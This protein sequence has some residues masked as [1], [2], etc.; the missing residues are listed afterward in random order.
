IEEQGSRGAGGAGGDGGEG[1]VGSVGRLGDSETR[2]RGEIPIPNRFD[3]NLLSKPQ[4]KVQG[5]G[6]IEG[7]LKPWIAAQ[8]S[9]QVFLGAA[10]GN[11]Q[12][13]AQ[14]LKEALAQLSQEQGTQLVRIYPDANAVTN[15]PV[16]QRDGKTI[17]LIQSWG[18][19]VEVGDWGQFSEKSQPDYDELL[20]AGRGDEIQFI[21]AAEYLELRKEATI[22][23]TKQISK[24]EWEL[25]FGLKDWLKKLGQQLK[26]ARDK[27]RKRLN[28]WGFSQGT[29][30][31]EAKPDASG[32]PNYYPA[33]QRL[34]T[35]ETT[36]K[37]T[38]DSSSTGTGKSFDTGTILPDRFDCKRAF[39]ITTDP[40]NPSTPTLKNWGYLDG[41]HSGLIEDE[42]GKL[43]RVK[44]GEP[45]S[46]SP[47]CF[48]TE[49]IAA[50]RDA[51]IRG[52]DDSDLVCQ[53]CPWFEA[54]KGGYV[55]GYLA[56]RRET[57]AEEYRI[58]S[59]P[60]SLPNE[61]EFQDYADSLL[62]WEEWE[63]VLTATREIKVHR[64]DLEKLIAHLLTSA[65]L[66]FTQLQPLLI[67]ISKI[68]QAKQPTRY[69]WNHQALVKELPRLP[70]DLALEAIAMTTQPNLTEVLDPFLEYGT[71]MMDLSSGVRKK[72]AES[73]ETTSAKARD[74]LKQWLIP[75]LNILQGNGG[76]LSMSSGI[77]TITIPDKRL[78]D[79]AHAAKKNVFLDATGHKEELV[80]LLGIDPDEIDHIA[81]EPSQGADLK[82]IQVAGM[83]RLG[84]QRGN[85]QQKQVEAV[86]NKL[87]VDYPHAGVIRFKRYAQSSL[88][89]GIDAVEP[90]QPS[91]EQ[92]RSR[93]YRWFIESRG[94]NDAESLNNLILDGIPCPNLES[95][96]A[97][98][99]C[100][101][102]RVPKE[103]IQKVEYPIQITNSLPKGIQPH[104]EMEVSA[105]PQFRDFVYRRILANIHQGIG[106]LRANRRSPDEQLTVYLL[107]DFA[108]DVPVQLIRAIDITLEAASKMEKFERALTEAIAQLKA[109][110]EKITQ[111][112][113]ANITGYSQG[114]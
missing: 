26:T 5:I 48:R 79:I 103:G 3:N 7:I 52:A 25:K 1:S 15:Y 110:G 63:T 53:T 27:T 107:G 94:V 28:A 111:Q 14:Q 16:Y 68:A 108:L 47:N 11:F 92:E 67:A 71:S 114:Y 109:T 10:G 57:L 19:Q 90:S 12:A 22:P 13:S 56:K 64:R 113:L 105:D 112:A 37:W 23:Y 102:G 42:H 8:L 66:I 20:A 59:H 39:Y 35:W 24:E 83:G 58:R 36:G 18:Y 98:F 55:Y 89:K 30:D 54:C 78:V 84:Q 96:A 86:I 77:L 43:R 85:Y 65:P 99:T 70:D 81:A 97:E 69:G 44:K 50:L 38:F 100:I 60:A 40:R 45:R 76:Y 95:L 104:F 9:R 87:L 33:E 106:R 61:G 49:T 88:T 101:Y 93:D 82:I 21:R 46:V 34:E 75:L 17:R 51:G 74:L 6:I 4:P 73:D 29:Q 41:R 31:V 91:S 32:K 80:L 62:I 72:F 2:R